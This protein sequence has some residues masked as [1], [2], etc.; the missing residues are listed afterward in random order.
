MRSN[1]LF[2]L[3]L[4]STLLGGTASPGVVEPTLQSITVAL[5]ELQTLVDESS[6]ELTEGLRFDLLAEIG[7]IQAKA[8]QRKAARA[9]FQKIFAHISTVTSENLDPYSDR[10][11][12]GMDTLFRL[13]L[14]QGQAEDPKGQAVTLDYIR[15][16]API[17]PD[18]YWS[19]RGNMG[20]GALLSLMRL[21]RTSLH[22]VKAILLAI[23]EL[24]E[25]E[26]S[27]VNVN[28]QY[29]LAEAYAALGQQEAAL[30]SLQKLPAALLSPPK[31]NELGL[32]SP[33]RLEAELIARM[34]KLP[35]L[36]S[37]LKQ[38]FSRISELA[39]WQQAWFWQ[40]MMRLVSALIEGGQVAE[41]KSLFDRILPLFRASPSVKGDAAIHKTFVWQQI[42]I[43]YAKLGN[44]EGVH[45]AERQAVLDRLPST[46]ML[47]DFWPHL[48][49][50]Q[51]KAGDLEGAQQTATRARHEALEYIA[52]I[53]LAQVEH[54][55]VAGA[56]VSLG[57]L[58]EWWAL[59]GRSQALAS[60]YRTTQ[61]P[62]DHHAAVRAVAKARVVDGDIYGTL[63]WAQKYPY[64]D[65]KAYALVGLAEGL[66]RHHGSA[67]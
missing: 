57:A 51:L 26:E 25:K 28:I 20:P 63:E 58:D 49:E 44:V 13:A 30:E 15:S 35:R 27:D 22:Q 66:L 47:R 33:I 43:I 65:L 40:G 42:A 37:Y 9:T 39:P 17:M 7:I 60:I 5:K 48:F 8:G 36:Q 4:I 52:D 12:Y 18:S 34:G 45:Q 61:A 16:L 46:E 50:F 2:G 11:S 62:P 14:A 41:A 55:D 23:P 1:L 24:V 38:D 3:L 32:H 6:S 10:L 53:I 31:T 29:F 19:R 21:R 54:G 56:Q 64:S 59:S 67:P